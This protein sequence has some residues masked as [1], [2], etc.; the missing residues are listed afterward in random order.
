MNKRYLR[1][2][3][4]IVTILSCTACS[5]ERSGV[6]DSVIQDNLVARDLISDLKFSHN[7][8]SKAHTDTVTIK[9]TVENDFAKSVG[10]G[11]QKYQYDK[12]SDL[13]KLTQNGDWVWEESL[14]DFSDKSPI[15]YSRGTGSTYCEYTIWVD[16][17]DTKD[18]TV[19]FR[20]MIY[21]PKDEVVI[22]GETTQTYPV[23]IT[24]SGAVYVDVEFEEGYYDLWGDDHT[25]LWF[26][27]EDFSEAS[28]FF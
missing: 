23:K 16:S 3:L 25:R 8:D 15:E 12:S 20:Y 2:I 18:C 27:E 14:K 5:S 26:N 19:T 24:N 28:I 6:P 11:T 7:V 4:L 10:T 17:V 22:Y 1:F 9:G 21:Y 13:W